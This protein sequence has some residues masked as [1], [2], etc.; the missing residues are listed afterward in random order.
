MNGGYTRI[1]AGG[2]AVRYSWK[3]FLPRW[4]SPSIGPGFYTTTSLA[5][6]WR[7]AEKRIIRRQGPGPA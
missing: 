3:N 7:W 1:G 5:Q 2:K 6:A 4:A